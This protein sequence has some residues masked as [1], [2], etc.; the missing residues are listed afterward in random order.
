MLYF[1]K[2]SLKQI[3]CNY[4][5]SNNNF[6]IYFG[7]ASLSI[8]TCILT[9]AICLSKGFSDEVQRKLSSI[10][11]HYRITSLYF[12]DDSYLNPEETENIISLISED[13]LFLSHSRYTEDYALANIKGGAEGLLVYGINSEEALN[14]FNV[15]LSIEDPV[16]LNIHSKDVIHISIGSKLAQSYNL[17]LGDQFYLLPIN[18]DNMKVLP[19]AKEVKVSHI[20]DSGF[21]EYDQFVCFIDLNKAQLL[22]EYDSNVA[23]IIGTIQNPLAINDTF[24]NLFEKIEGYKIITWIDRHQNIVKWLDVYSAPIL[25]VILLVAIL[26]IFNMSLSIWIFTQ[27]YMQQLS[28]LLTI[29]FTKFKLFLF[30]MFQNLTMTF[31]SLLS[32]GI[33]SFLLLY[34]QN[35]YELIKIP[36]DVYFT[37]YLPVTFDYLLVFKYYIS[38]FLISFFISLF[39]A[40]KLRSLNIVQYLNP[41]D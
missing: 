3:A 31:I 15:N 19:V 16:N 29:G 18:I 12:E 39:P 28:I 38:L 35:K 5:K 37:H 24:Y 21:S 26:A 2:I 4:R 20:F 7:V 10:D 32:S 30:I 25:F 14:I 27:D 9:L 6:I 34:I 17:Q 1:I 41:N 33:I 13:S 22:F 23:G 40:F 11:G 8:C 36:E